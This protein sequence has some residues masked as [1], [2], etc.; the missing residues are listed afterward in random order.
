M[1]GSKNLLGET[2]LQVFKLALGAILGLMACSAPMLLSAKERTLYRFTGGTDGYEPSGVIHD[3][4]GNLYGVTIQGGDLNCYSG[5]GCGTVFK[6]AADGTKTTLY[7]FHLGSDGAQPV[8]RLL[9]D[10]AGNLFGTTQF[11]GSYNEGIV[12]KLSPEGILKVLHA[13]SGGT[14]GGGP[15]S[16][17]LI[18]D[19]SGN[20]YGTAGSGGDPNCLPS[21]GCGVVFKLTPAGKETVLHAFHGG[22]D[23]AYPAGGV[24]RDEEGNL[25]GTTVEGG[26]SANCN[27]GC[28]TI[29]KI[30][31]DG[32]ETVLHSFNGSDAW[33]PVDPPVMDET[34]NLYGTTAEGGNQNCPPG[35]GVVYRLAANGGF[36]VIYAFL[37]GRSGYYP[38]GGLRIVGGSLFGATSEGGTAS[39]GTVF[40][41]D[42][43]GAL[44]LLHNFSGDDGLYP[45]A[46]LAQQDGFLYGTTAEGGFGY[47]TV[48]KVQAVPNH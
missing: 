4:D 47:G 24:Y 13:F 36:S 28:G 30:A 26:G 7:A 45:N 27:Y 19:K 1:A 12:F 31:T 10:S 32:T 29:F 20:L 18:S 38:A 42:S 23:G 40:R 14:D 34:G 37:G 6:I 2:V 35:C 41:L 39:G 3:R 21:N 16:V 43:R 33:F 8:G 9:H 44:R 48:F 15:G 17:R 22:S 46:D 25:Y 11:G 5:S